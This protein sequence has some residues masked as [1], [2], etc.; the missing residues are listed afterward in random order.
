VVDLHLLIACLA[1][2]AAGYLWLRSRVHIGHA[3]RYGQA[4]ARHLQTPNDFVITGAWFKEHR[5][6]T[7]CGPREL[8]YGN[9][10]FWLCSCGSMCLVFEHDDPDAPAET[11]RRA[12]GDV[13][14]QYCELLYRSHPLSGPLNKAGEFYLHRLCDGS[15]VHL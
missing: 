9:V 7:L 4:M 2:F 10:Y 13:A 5:P 14:C 12:S 1:I 6:H 3:C 11:A 15:L 8:R